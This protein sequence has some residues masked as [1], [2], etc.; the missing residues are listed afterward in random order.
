MANGCSDFQ[1]KEVRVHLYALDKDIRPIG[2]LEG[3]RDAKSAGERIDSEVI[4][5]KSEGG[6]WQRRPWEWNRGSAKASRP[7]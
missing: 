4:V 2:T 3:P 7:C 5:K 6:K 1:E